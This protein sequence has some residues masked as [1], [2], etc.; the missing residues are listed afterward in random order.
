MSASAIRPMY[1]QTIDRTPPSARPASNAPSRSASG[2]NGRTISDTSAP[3]DTF[4]AYGTNSPRSASR[5]ISATVV[6]ALSCASRVDAPRCGVT[7]TRSDPK[8]GLS[9]VGSTANTSSA[10][11]PSWPPSSAFASASSST[12][13]PRAV[14][15]RRAPGF[16]SDSSCSP[17]R[18]SVSLVRGRWIVTKSAWTSSASSV[19]IT[20][21]PISFARSDETYGSYA[22]TRMPNAAARCATSPPTR[23]SPITPIVLP[24]SSTPSHSARSHRPAVSAACACGMFR[25]CDSSSAS[26]CSAAEIT[27][28]CGAF[29]TITPRRVAASTSTLSRPIP[30][31]ATT[32]SRSAASRTCAVTCVWDRTIS[33]SYGAISA[34]RSPVAS[35]GRTSTSKSRRSSSRPCSESFS[36]TRTRTAG[37]ASASCASWK[38]PSAAATAAPRFTG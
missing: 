10:A 24:A 3:A 15:T 13:P 22:I 18:P 36:V 14:F 20:S 7:T 33:A 16:I 30:A 38:T 25:A 5:T 11:P 2:T 26:V 32:R 23:P 21:T 29:T 8:I 12:M 28:D 37:Y 35:S 31:R 19:G 9:V 27:L 17:I 6:P 34:A 1:E 4:T